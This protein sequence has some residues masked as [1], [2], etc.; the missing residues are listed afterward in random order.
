MLRYQLVLL[1]LQQDR[2]DAAMQAL[3]DAVASGLPRSVLESSPALSGLRADPRFDALLAKAEPGDAIGHNP[4][5]TKPAEPMLVPNGVALVDTSNTAWDPQ[6]GMLRSLFRIPADRR[7]AGPVADNVTGADQLNA[8][9]RLG[10]AA[11]NLGDLYDNRDG[12]HSLLPSQDFPQLTRIEYSEEARQAGLDRSLNRFFLYNAVTIGNASLALTGGPMWRS[13]P[14]QALTDPLQMSGLF[15]QY[16]A[17]HL[18]VYPA[19]QD[20][21]TARGDL[22]PANTPYMLVSVGSSGSDQPLV[23]AV[24]SILAA[25][26]PEVKAFS[27]RA[28]SHFA[29]GAVDFPSRAVRY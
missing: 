14:R 4:G 22:F 20:Y 9:F 26:R 11:G 8:W 21:G 28:R 19:H 7:N 2:K 27:R 17:N 10:T 25:F 13:L 16:S 18:Y 12:G 23:K 15:Q 5:A 24:A 3:A 1:L 6:L 29:D